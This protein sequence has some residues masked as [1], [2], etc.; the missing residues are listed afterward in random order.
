MEALYVDS[1]AAITAGEQ[2][3][4]GGE[5]GA[6]EREQAALALAASPEKVRPPECA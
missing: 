5:Q 1:L 4:A 3:A 6:A 2:A